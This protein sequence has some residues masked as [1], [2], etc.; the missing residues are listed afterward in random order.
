MLLS[1][2]L[3][4]NNL[5]LISCGLNLLRGSIYGRPRDVSHVFG[6]KNDMKVQ[7]EVDIF[8]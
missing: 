1:F 7:I 5:C 3:N 4:D 6:G 2:S 8:L